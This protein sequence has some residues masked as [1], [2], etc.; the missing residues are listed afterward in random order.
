MIINLISSKAS[1]DQLGSTLLITFINTF[2][3]AL[4][5]YK[6]DYKRDDRPKANHIMDCNH[7]STSETWPSGI[8]FTN[9]FFRKTSAFSAGTG[10]DTKKP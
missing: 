8:S 2:I 7:N 6:Y 9:E 10:V 4:R 5:T 3:R 1:I